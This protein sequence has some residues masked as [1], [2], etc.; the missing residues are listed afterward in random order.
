MG[1]MLRLLA[2]MVFFGENHVFLQLSAEYAYL[3]QRELISTLKNLSCR[4]YS[5]QKLTQFSQGNNVL[6]FPASN[7]DG[8]L[9]SYMSFLNS[10]DEFCTYRANLQLEI[11]KL[12]E[13][14]LSKTNSIISGKQCT[15]YSC[16]YHR[17]IPFEKY[18]SFFNSS[19]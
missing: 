15:R 6:D 12:Q 9:E 14:F 16:F 5:F 17:W 1:Y 13:I 18:V 2:Q 11:P 3:C 10:D 19:E 4:R 8:S 7:T